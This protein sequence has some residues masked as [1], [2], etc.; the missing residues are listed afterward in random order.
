[1]KY[2]RTLCQVILL[3]LFAFGFS[4]DN[5][6]SIQTP[7]PRELRSYIF[8]HSLIH[9]ELQ[10]I[11]TPSQET[12]VPHWL[13][14][15]AETAG[16]SFNASGQ[17]GFLPQHAQL[18]PVAQW[19][20]D[21]FPGVWD[22]ESQSFAEAG[23]NSV[24]LTAG[25]FMQWQAATEN[26][27]NESFSPLDA[28]LDIIDWVSQATPGI[29]IYIYENWPDM[30]PFIQSFPPLTEELKSYHSYT[31]GEFHSWWLEYHDKLMEVRPDLTIKMI[32]VG[33]IL[34]KLLTRPFLQDIPISELY[35]DDAPHGRASLYF[36]AAMVT[37]MAMYGTPTPEAFELPES[38][39]PLIS[40]AYPEIV[41]F[42][43]SELISFTDQQGKS[44]VW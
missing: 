32:P 28:S 25:N 14:L 42:I 11:A 27:P 15:L 36:L 29:P 3:L 10:K 41:S 1:M 12:S 26:Y 30:A 31:S 23:F 18:P 34:S 37:Y 2:S 38:I 4:Q 16:F 22:S 7:V 35:E 39:H 43:W 6:T 5:P 33:P 17:Y 20:F 8:G 24:L 13:Y 44:R 40:E 19:G 9:H 21:L